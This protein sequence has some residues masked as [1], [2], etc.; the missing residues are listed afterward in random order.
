MSGAVLVQVVLLALGAGAG[1][2]L[3]LLV[4]ARA[5][6]SHHHLVRALG[7]AWVNVPASTVAGLALAWLVVGAGGAP[8]GATWSASALVAAAALGVCGG[9]S[10]WSSLALEV[11][12]AVRAGDSA[13]LRT[14]AAGVG[15]GVVGGV[16]GVGAGV[17]LAGLTGV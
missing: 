14:Q 10:T 4:V 17:L 13:L 12:G 1:A 15:L 9:L 11:A 16:V 3:R 2:A 8:F 7:T 5:G 6:A